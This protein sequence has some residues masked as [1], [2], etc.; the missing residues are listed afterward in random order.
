[1]RYELC[2][3]ERMCGVVCSMKSSD[4]DRRRQFAEVVSLFALLFAGYRISTTV[5]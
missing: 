4:V 5:G 2:A 1:M 3:Q